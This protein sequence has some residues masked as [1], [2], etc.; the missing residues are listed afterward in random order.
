[1]ARL[2][3]AKGK[4][5]CSRARI[6]RQLPA[7]PRA[8]SSRWRTAPSQSRRR[9][10]PHPAGDVQDPRYHRRPAAGRRSLRGAQAEGAGDPRRGERH[11][12]LR[13]GDQGQAPP[14]HHGGRRRDARVPDPEV[15]QV[16]CYE[17]EHVERGESHRR[18]RGE[19]AR[20]PASA[21]RRGPGRVHRATR[22]RTSTA[23]R[24][25]RST[26]STSRSSSARCCARWRSAI[27][28]TRLPCRRADRARRRCW[29]R[30]SVR[31]RRKEPATRAHA[32]RHHQ[33]L[34]GD[35]VVHLGG[36]VPGDDPGAHRGGRHAAADDLR[37]LKENVIVGRLI[38][39]GT[40]LAHHASERRER[41]K[42]EPNAREA[43]AAGSEEAPPR[44]PSA[45]RRPP[46]SNSAQPVDFAP[47]QAALPTGVRSRSALTG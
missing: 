44:R 19:P 29:R 37:G 27:R 32:A 33:G 4:D 46:S 5:V 16:T 42:S 21:G 12:Q 23:C 6:R 11:R 3:D 45:G 31:S 9:A 30:T 1:M 41:E 34:A 22:S 14:D 20:H 26:T 10:R 39:A 24:A 36:I 35:R 40:G 7:S 38:P 15:A 25:S 18:W 8:R 13:Q 2:V 17:G 47:G 43:A 28:A